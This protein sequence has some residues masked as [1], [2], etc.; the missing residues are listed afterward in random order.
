MTPSESEFNDPA[1]NYLLE[2]LPASSR[3]LVQHLHKLGAIQL[4]EKDGQ[5]YVSWDE[6]GPYIPPHP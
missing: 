1:A 6:L 5:L 2:S 4:F 3:D